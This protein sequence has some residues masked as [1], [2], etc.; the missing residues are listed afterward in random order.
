MLW[1]LEIL[2]QSNKLKND[3]MMIPIAKPLI[4]D[5]EKKAVIRVLESGRL[6]QGKTVEEFE[7][8]FASYC[9]VKYGITT[10]NGT[11][12]LHTAVMALGIEKEDEVITSPL[13]FVASSNCLLYVGAKPVFVDIDPKTYNIDPDLIEEKITERTKA[14]LP[15]HLY[16]QPCDMD[17][18]M[19][20]ARKYN[21]LVIEDASQAHGAEFKGKK[22]GSFGNVACFS[23]Y[24]TKNMTT[25][26]GGIVLTNSDDI[27]NKCRLIRNHGQTDVYYH[28]VLGFNFRMTEIQAAIG[29]EQLKKLNEWNETRIKNA[30]FLTE[31]L[32][33]LNDIITPYVDSRVKHVFHQYTIRIK[34]MSNVDLSKKL[35]KRGIQTK[36]YY[37]IPIHKQIFYKK[38]GYNDSLFEAE[39]ASKEILSIPVHPSL[40]K[41]DLEKIV[42]QLREILREE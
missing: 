15:V 34:K 36:I 19:K 41:G 25:A 17:K 31:N 38:L 14:I 4:S 26:E 32:K 29:I 1:F 8:K 11:T 23:F 42:K 33:D 37:P 39:L 2:Q 16:G 13:S 35:E 6:T 10:S 7:K 9:D 27:D 21:L 24:P 3:D 22:I 30:K 12:A 5:E 28:N 18:I 20:I 40:S